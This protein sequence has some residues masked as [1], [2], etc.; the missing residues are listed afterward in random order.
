MCRDDWL[1]NDISWTRT[2]G[3][4][5]AS[6]LSRPAEGPENRSP[7]LPRRVAVFNAVALGTMFL[8]RARSI[9]F[10]SLRP[11]YARLNVCAFAAKY[12][13]YVMHSNKCGQCCA[14]S[15][16]SP[17]ALDS[18]GTATATHALSRRCWIIPQ[19]G[20][21]P[22]QF[23]LLRNLEQVPATGIDSIGMPPS[24]PPLTLHGKLLT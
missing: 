21:L 23:P 15:R 3:A 8:I 7:G 2:C 14:C 4:S 18:P 12:C 1:M 13:C 16:A 24:L 19:R 9:A 11:T 6:S 20:V 10:S 5:W 17:P 22:R